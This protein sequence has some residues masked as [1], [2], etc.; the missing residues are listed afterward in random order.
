MSDQDVDVDILDLYMEAASMSEGEDG[1]TVNVD[2][3]VDTELKGI[4]D[5]RLQVMEALMKKE[6]RKKQKDKKKKLVAKNPIYI[7][8]IDTNSSIIDMDF[9]YR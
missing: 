4:E 9:L 6:E 2:Q 3:E 8:I 5:I 7:D 1:E